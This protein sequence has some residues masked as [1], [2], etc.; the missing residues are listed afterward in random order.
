MPERGLLGALLRFAAA[1]GHGDKEEISA[2]TG[3]PTGTSTGK[4]EPMIRYAWAMGLINALRDKTNWQ[5][6]LTPLGEAVYR[7]DLFLNEPVTLWL[8]HLMISRRFDASHPP[9]GYADAWFALFAEGDTLLGRNFQEDELHRIFI[10]RYGDKGYLSR[11]ASLIPRM[12]CETSSFGEARILARDSHETQ[13][14][15]RLSAPTDSAFYPAYAYFL[16][17]TW[18][19]LFGPEYT[20]IDFDELARTSRLLS[21]L[22][23]EKEQTN[24]W[25]EWMANRGWVQVDRRT[26][27]AMLLRLTKSEKILAE[28]YAELV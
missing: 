21:L 28:L 17:I 4:V 18:D 11:L 7:E 16:Y 8:L 5:L 13:T 27:S 6:S 15:I 25:M 14:L 3:I 10:Q 9:T 24:I 19:E 2:A 12:Y 23:W 26:G 20:Q 22:G 1:G